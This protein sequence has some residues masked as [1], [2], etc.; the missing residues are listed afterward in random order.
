MPSDKAS[1]SPK[2]RDYGECWNNNPAH[3]IESKAPGL[4]VLLAIRHLIE[5]LLT[6]LLLTE[7]ICYVTDSTGHYH[8][9]FALITDRPR[10]PRNGPNR[11]PLRELA[12]PL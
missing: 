7:N 11:R 3:I 9:G 6:P 10:R 4:M 1:L 2:P 8:C 12:V 5:A